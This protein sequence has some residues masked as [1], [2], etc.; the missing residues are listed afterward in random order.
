[1]RIFSNLANQAKSNLN[2]SNI[3]ESIDD[4]AQLNADGQLKNKRINWRR[5]EDRQIDELIGMCKMALADGHV[6]I[7]EAKA[8]LYWLEQNKESSDRWP[9]NVMYSRIYAILEDG[10][11]DTQEENDLIDLLLEATGGPLEKLLVQKSTS[12]PLCSPAPEISFP[13]KNFCLTGKFFYGPR[14]NCEKIIIDMGGELASSPTKK[15]D[16][17]VI[18]M[19]GSEQWV[20]STHGRK[21]ETGV[22]LRDAGNKI[23]I[24][25]EEHW[26]KYIQAMS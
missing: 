13:A 12:L 5:I 25:S 24:I 2:P 3:K 10:I 26:T 17:L 23:R 6:D 9:A 7:L 11:I 4:I 20:H 16:Y 1:M 15:T 18:G 22:E 8:L 21:I 19:I 14:K